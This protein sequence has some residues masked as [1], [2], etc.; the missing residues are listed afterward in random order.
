MTGI[1]SD[2]LVKAS[3]SIP[4]TWRP[5][6]N[7]WL[8]PN[9]SDPV[10]SVAMKESI[11]TRVIRRPFTRPT[12]APVAITSRDVVTQSRPSSDCSPIA[13]IWA[14]PRTEATE[15][16]K[17]LVI[18][19]IMNAIATRALIER[20]FAIVWKVKAVGKV[21][22]LRMVNTTMSRTRRSSSPQTDTMR[23]RIA[24]GPSA[25]VLPPDVMTASVIRWR[26]TPGL[27]GVPRTG[28][29][30]RLRRKFARG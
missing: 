2:K 24:S 20:A 27:S 30:A 3:G 11:L 28:P 9:R 4:I 22:G 12:N 15:R 13:R 26:L 7:H 19:G 16:S 1:R 17:L 25:G 8:K 6:V 18:S 21:S 23:R 10:P 14:M 5:P 29:L